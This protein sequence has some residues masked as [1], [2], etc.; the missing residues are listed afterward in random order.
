MFNQRN[1]SKDI[2]FV[3]PGQP[4]KLK[5]S[6]YTSQKYGMTNGVAEQVSTDT[7][8]GSNII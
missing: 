5:V 7:S 6:S 3:R 1:H 8:D 2:G 4:V